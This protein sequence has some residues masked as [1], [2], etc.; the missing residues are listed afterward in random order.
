[1]NPSHHLLS[2]LIAGTLLVAGQLTQAQQSTTPGPDDAQTYFE[3]L[4]SDF[5]ASKI[6][7]INEVMKLTGPEAGIFW[8]IYREYEIKLAAIGDRKLALIRQFV[9]HHQNGTLN[10]RNAGTLAKQWLKNS[11]QRLDLWTQYHKKITKAVSAMRAA[12][13]LQVEHQMAL[14]VDIAIASEMPEVSAGP[15]PAPSK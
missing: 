5:N 2:C 14:F 7:A 15:L 13:F 1:M 4:R 9:A 6:R 8:P 3:M 10:D 12:Q 11:R